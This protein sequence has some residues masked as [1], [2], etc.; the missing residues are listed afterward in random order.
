VRTKTPSEAKLVERLNELAEIERK[1]DETRREVFRQWAE[2]RAAEIREGREPA[3]PF[4]LLRDG[5]LEL[6]LRREQLLRDRLVDQPLLD[7]AIANINAENAAAGSLAGVG[8]SAVTGKTADAAA[9][10]R[11]TPQPRCLR[12]PSSDDAPLVERSR[13]LRA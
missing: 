2:A 5:E 7:R 13:G 11:G 10:S 9:S 8:N 4:P 1:H 12:T 6:V 3:G